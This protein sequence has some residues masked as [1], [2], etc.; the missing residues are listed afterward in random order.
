MKLNQNIA[1]STS[2]EITD[3]TFLGR[4]VGEAVEFH[5]SVQ[6]IHQHISVDRRLVHT[7]QPCHDSDG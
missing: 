3:R 5:R 4:G 2:T 6:I 1:F 7:R